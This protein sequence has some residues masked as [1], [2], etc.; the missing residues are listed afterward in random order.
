MLPSYKRGNTE[1]YK[2]GNT[3]GEHSL[4]KFESSKLYVLL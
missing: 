1:Y 4:H 2:S 3:H